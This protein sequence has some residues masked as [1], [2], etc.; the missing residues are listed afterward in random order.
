LS[1]HFAAGQAEQL[2]VDPAD[3][4]VASLVAKAGDRPIVIVGRHIHRSA[5]AA[6]FTEAL[7]AA[8]PTVVV[9]MGWPAAWRPAGAR[10]F[11]NTFGASRANGRAAALALGLA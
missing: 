4:T 6:Q 1:A 10:A 3:V 8:H 9:E 5:V 2:V 7:A 11:M